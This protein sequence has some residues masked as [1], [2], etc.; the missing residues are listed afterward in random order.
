MVVKV[1]N[2][3]GGQFSFSRTKYEIVSILISFDSM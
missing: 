1:V 2:G 3:I